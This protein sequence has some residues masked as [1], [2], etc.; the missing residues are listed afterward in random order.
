MSAVYP[1][2]IEEM[3]KMLQMHGEHLLEMHPRIKSR[4]IISSNDN[5][6]IVERE[7]E[8]E[9]RRMRSTWKYTGI[10]EGFESEILDG[11]YIFGKGS[12][13]TNR[14]ESV[15]AGTQVTTIGEFVIPGVSEEDGRRIVEM[16]G[17]RA[18]RED[19]EVLD[20]MKQEEAIRT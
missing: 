17:E 1:I 7:V 8:I 16:W 12:R 11:E 18:D 6:S 2:S 13:W 10:P 15:P 5:I 3:W 19:L 9:G 20:K 14:Y 4:R